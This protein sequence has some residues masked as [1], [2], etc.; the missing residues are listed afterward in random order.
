V[1]YSILMALDRDG[2]NLSY[3]FDELTIWRTK[4]PEVKHAILPPSNNRPNPLVADGLVFVSV[5]APGAICAL[6]RKT[7]VLVWRRELPKYA[8][9]AV[10]VAN[11]T[12]FAQ[13]PTTLY[14]L[15]PATGQTVWS[16]CP[17]GE[18]SETMYSAP[19]VHENRVFM[20]PTRAIPC[21]NGARAERRIAI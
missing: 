9:A 17:Y 1:W 21:G 7:G 12:L 18:S 6:D 2:K 8:S 20:I 5:F 11:G 16:F 15:E 4:L 10:H 14:A 3:E 19:T 13:S